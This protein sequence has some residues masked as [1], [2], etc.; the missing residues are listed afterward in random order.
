MRP[1]TVL[2]VHF[3]TPRMMEACI[4]SLSRQTPGCRV[5]VFDNSTS[6]PFDPSCCRNDDADVEV[7]DNTRGQ[8]IDFDRWLQRFPERRPASSNYGSPKHAKTISIC[9]S[10][11]PDGFI[12]MD[13]DVLFKRDI[14]PMWDETKA[15]VGEPFLDTPK[16][17][18]VMRL[19]PFLCYINVP[20]CRDNDISYF[21]ARWM[22]HLTQAVPNKWY[23]TGAWFYKACMDRHLPHTDIKTADYIE[24]YFHGSHANLNGGME[25]WLQKNKGLWT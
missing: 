3:N 25:E 21:N 6:A 15:W 24:H 13:S 2:T 12:L 22:W 23:D 1:I 19:L 9:F 10:L 5:V 17:V 7:I 20:L 11:L 4:R 14:A 18:R 16:G 8:V